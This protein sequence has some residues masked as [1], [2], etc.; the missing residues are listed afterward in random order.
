M[1]GGK[2]FSAVQRMNRHIS[3]GGVVYSNIQLKLDPWHND[4]YPMKEFPLLICPLWEKV[5]FVPECKHVWQEQRRVPAVIDTPKG[6]AYVCN[7]HGA[8]FF[9][10]RFLKWHYQDGQYNYVPDELVNAQ[11][12]AHLPTGAVDRPVLVVLDEALDHFEAGDGNTNAEF[13]S[14]L[15]HV[16]K[17]G[18]NLI[19]IAQDFGSMEKKF[20]VLV[21]YVWTFRDLKAWKVPVIGAFLPGG[22]LPP[23][24]NDNIQQRQYHQKQFGQAKAEPINKGIYQYRDSL[25]FQCYQ[26]VS[27]H[28]ASI[29]MNGKAHDFGESGRITKG[30]KRMNKFERVAIYGL[31]SLSLW[32]AF[33]KS[34]AASA[35][36]IG[37]GVVSV[38][39]IEKHEDLKDGFVRNSAG[40]IVERLPI[41]WTGQGGVSNFWIE[42]VAV[43]SGSVTSRGVVESASSTAVKFKDIDGKARWV[44]HVPF[45]SRGSNSVA[46]AHSKADV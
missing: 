15:R 10:A 44:Y 18:I 1:G 19:F 6:R 30:K 38:A 45:I 4:D 39:P 40:E 17:L 24:W 43:S 25:I 42:G 23:P 20:R 2:S 31:L 37:S 21:Y 11:L 13:R 28:N 22:V 36:V 3:N 9:L 16:R 8:V 35:P 27:L 46:M 14:F 32:V 41:S 12:P 7:S 29:T 5:G 34:A 33:K 26:S